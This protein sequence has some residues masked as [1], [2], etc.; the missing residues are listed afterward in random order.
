[1]TVLVVGDVRGTLERMKPVQRSY[2]GSHHITL[3]HHQ[4]SPLPTHT[5]MMYTQN[6]NVTIACVRHEI[7][8]Y[9]REHIELPHDVLQG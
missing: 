6:T 7:R 9:L 8:T 1:M 2:L 5:Y 3:P 4:G